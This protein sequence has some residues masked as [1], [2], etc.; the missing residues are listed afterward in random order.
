VIAT[1]FGLLA[2]RS[3]PSRAESDALAIRRVLREARDSLALSV[4]IPVAGALIPRAV[5]TPE[6]AVLATD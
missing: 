1:I 2:A 3:S 5:T 6:P 4:I